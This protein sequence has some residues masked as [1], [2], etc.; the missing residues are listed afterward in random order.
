M[1]RRADSG[2]PASEMCQLHYGDR[3]DADVHQGGSEVPE[4]KD[5][6]AGAVVIIHDTAQYIRLAAAGSRA[7][8]LPDRL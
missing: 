8:R 3:H 7:G 6:P 5:G 2:T 4:Q 1:L